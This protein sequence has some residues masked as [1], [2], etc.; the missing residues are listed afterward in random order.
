[1]VEGALGGLYLVEPVP[2]HD[3]D[4]ARLGDRL[5]DAGLLLHVLL[6]YLVE[7]QLRRLEFGLG[8]RPRGLRLDNRRYRDRDL[9]VAGAEAGGDQGLLGGGVEISPQLAEGGVAQDA[10][11]ALL[12]P[13]GGRQA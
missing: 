7:R 5:E 6:L 1:K 8:R 3:A 9:D 2:R 12:E 13:T 10:A 4:L 11:H